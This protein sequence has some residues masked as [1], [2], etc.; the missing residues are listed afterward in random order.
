MIPALHLI[1]DDEILRRDGF[2]T[3]A[4]KALEAGGNSVAL[5]LRG[6]GCPG[7]LLFDLARKLAVPARACGA[8]L[9]VNDRVDVALALTLEGV[10]L[11]QRSLPVPVA[12]RLLGS[13]K[14]LGAS[15]HSREETRL[16][17]EG[18][19]YLIV[20]AL[21][22]T[23][24]HPEAIPGGMERLQSVRDVTHLPL[25]GI[26]GITPGRVPGI[27]SARAHGVAVRGGVWHD[28]DPAAA[29]GVFLD[30]VKGGAKGSVAADGGNQG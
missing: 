14:L 7:R 5:H 23:P 22:P 3:R 12:R 8:K 26:G 2:L 15:V 21:F 19:D 24:S 27:L 29:V 6:P 17:G 11:G 16:V 18:A 1:T 13:G 4:Q 28:P 25:I 10:H 20:G 9:L 30:A